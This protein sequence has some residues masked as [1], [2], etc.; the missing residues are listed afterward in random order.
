MWIATFGLQISC[1]LQAMSNLVPRVLSPPP[2]S[3]GRKRKVPG[4]EV[5]RWGRLVTRHL[6]N[7]LWL[8]HFDLRWFEFWKA[9]ELITILRATWIFLVAKPKYLALLATAAVAFGPWSHGSGDTFWFPTEKSR[10]VAKKYDISFFS[11]YFF[12]IGKGDGNADPWT[13]FMRARMK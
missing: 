2:L 8:A 6:I 7:H 13:F 9:V 5:G 3:P 4:N 1:L 10:Q 11:F 12:S